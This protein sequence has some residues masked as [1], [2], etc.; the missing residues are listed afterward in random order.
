MWV[1][2]DA[3]ILHFNSDQECHIEA[4]LPVI[5]PHYALINILDWSGAGEENKTTKPT[6]ILLDRTKEQCIVQV[7]TKCSPTANG[8]F[9]H[10]GRLELFWSETPET[11][12]P[13]AQRR[14]LHS[15]VPPILQLYLLT[16]VLHG[17]RV[18]QMPYSAPLL[19]MYN[20]LVLPISIN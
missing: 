14:L 6:R 4:D 19:I 18:F 1:S 13:G 17:V 16:L 5:P 11:R 20:S 3:S 7:L 15:T 9:F 8:L 2:V 10:D 12:P